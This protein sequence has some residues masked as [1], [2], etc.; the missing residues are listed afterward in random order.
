MS[1]LFSQKPDSAI[2]HNSLANLTTGD[3]HTQYFLLAG[4]AGGQSPTG[5][6]AA[7]ENL[8]L[9]STSHA[10]KGKILF[11]NSIYDEVNSGMA[12]GNNVLPN[13]G[14]TKLYIQKGAGNTLPNDSN[15]LIICDSDTNATNFWFNGKTFANGG[16]NLTIGFTV[17]G[18]FKHGFVYNI[19]N[20]RLYLTK[21]SSNSSPTNGFYLDG[22]GNLVSVHT[23]AFIDLAGISAGNPNLKIT[24]TSDVPVVAFTGG[25]NAPTTAPAGYLE[26]LVGASSRYIPFWA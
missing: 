24:A 13:S 12:I 2:D 17:A 19:Q 18:A 8:T 22:N 23:G 11:G 1:F 6:N 16:T 14:N 20:D 9:R 4:R 3:P 10:T 21:D 15:S 26:I 7:S 5:G 25:G